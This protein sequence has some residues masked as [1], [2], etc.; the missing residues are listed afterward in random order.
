MTGKKSLERYKDFYSFIFDD[1]AKE[2][3]LYYNY[4]GSDF[5]VKIFR[6]ADY[7]YPH[8]TPEALIGGL[9]FELESPELA[10]DMTNYTDDLREIIAQI[11][12]DAQS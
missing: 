8:C 2:L 4:A 1:E 12:Q 6:L 11:K 7:I 10:E 3:R 9:L 5:L